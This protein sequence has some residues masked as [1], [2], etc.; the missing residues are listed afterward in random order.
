MIVSTSVSRW[1]ISSTSLPGCTA[2]GGDQAPCFGPQFEPPVPYLFGWLSQNAQGWSSDNC[3]TNLT[4][5][6]CRQKPGG[7]TD[8]LPEQHVVDLLEIPAETTPGDYV[9]QYRHDSEQTDQVWTT[10]SDIRIVA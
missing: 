6:E 1:C 9:L 3:G 2:G 7:W 4:P 10:C 5:E 8:A